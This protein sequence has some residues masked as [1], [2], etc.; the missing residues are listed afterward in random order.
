MTSL[1]DKVAEPA[2]TD[3]SS[4][5][6]T[7]DGTCEGRRFAS[8]IVTGSI[9][10]LVNLASRW[11]L[12]QVMPYE[13]AVSV[14]YLF[15]MTTAFLLARMF[16]FLASGDSWLAEYGRFALVNTFSFFVVLGV[17][18]GMLRLV[19]PFI[20]CNWH[21]EEIAHLVGVVSPIVLSYYAH[22]HYSFGEKTK[23]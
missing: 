6:S 2:A 4:D 1:S 21:A 9:A 17:S 12:S 7:G 20:G 3:G 22:K 23:P 13:A 8:F 19:L 16:V 5:K 15:G 18:A 14:A 11:L 10:A